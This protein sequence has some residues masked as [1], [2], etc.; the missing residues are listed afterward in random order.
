MTITHVLR[1]AREHAT[2]ILFMGGFI[3]DVLVLPDAGH[4]ITM[5]LGTVYLSIVAIAIA[6]RERVISQNKATTKEQKLYSMLTFG[7]AYFSGSALSFISVYSL[8]SAALS[9][10]WPL[11]IILFLCV[12][13]NEIISSHHFRFTLD[14]AVLFIAS[15]FFIV[16]NV[17]I[18]LKLQNDTTFLISCAIAVVGTLIYSFFLQYTSESAGEEVSKL[19]ALS[20]GIPLFVMMLYF[21]NVIP[22]VP[23]SIKKAGI[24]HSITHQE[25]GEFLAIKEVDRRFL[26]SL[27]VPVYYLQDDYKGVYFFSAVSAP[28]ELAAPLSHVWEKYNES[29]KKWEA[30][31]TIEFTLAGGR[32][33]GYRAYSQ[34]GNI[35]PGLW[36]VS[37]KVDTN[38]IVGRMKF[39]I[40]QAENQ[41]VKLINTKL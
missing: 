17:P 15:L 34:K 6:L 28:A 12:L 39:Y 29:T 25:G 18:L 33:D 24:Y 8:R 41:E 13:M 21:L 36:R 37:V 19:Y 7:I 2:T 38:R 40:Q 1:H 31:T 35:S 20:I 30:L 10:S 3:F 26:G 9:V 27:R 11:I 23:L 14:V 32:E 16:F 4:E 5:W 22:A